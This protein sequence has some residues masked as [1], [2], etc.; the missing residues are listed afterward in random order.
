M[1][2]AAQAP[3]ADR[4]HPCA[5]AFLLVFAALGVTLVARYHITPFI[6]RFLVP[7]FPSTDPKGLSLFLRHLLTFS[8]PTAVVCLL[9]WAWMARWELLPQP[10]PSLTLGAAPLRTLTHGLAGGALIAGVTVV[11]VYVSQHGLHWQPN[12]WGI[13]GNCFSNFYEEVEYRGFITEAGLAAFRKARWAILLGAA[14]FG[15]SHGTLGGGRMMLA[16]LVGVLLGFVYY[17]TRSLWAPWIVHQVA[18]VVAD[19]LLG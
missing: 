16:T 1:D 9:A 13:A 12:G 19:S 8:L 5:R 14:A 3:V 6:A 18:D 17:R 4:A 15:L 10:W 11:C 7:L 2:P